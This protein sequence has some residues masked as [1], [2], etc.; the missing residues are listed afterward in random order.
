VLV[1]RGPRAGIEALRAEVEAAMAPAPDAEIEEALL[2]LSTLTKRTARD[3]ENPDVQ[4]RAYVR[5]LRDWP[6]DIV[7][8]VLTTWRATTFWP[9]MFELAAELDRAAAPRR[10]KLAA[11]RHW[12]EY[13]EDQPAERAPKTPESRARV[14][15]IVDDFAAG[16]RIPA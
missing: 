15:R 5:Q 6:G 3:D 9:T 12:P 13:D 14:Q 8:R 10:A 7:W 1:A 16:R 11:L 4:L 2:V